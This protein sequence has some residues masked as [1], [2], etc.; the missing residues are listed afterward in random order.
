MGRGPWLGEKPPGEQEV[1]AGG[2]KQKRPRP[3]LGLG[4]PGQAESDEAE[5]E[6]RDT[7]VHA[8]TAQ[9]F[10]AGFSHFPVVFGFIFS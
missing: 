9:E 4:G 10:C 3:A 5:M 1:R 2:L 6:A 8:D 7:T